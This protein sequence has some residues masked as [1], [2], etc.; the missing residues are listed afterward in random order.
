MEEDIR[1]HIKTKDL[2]RVLDL[3]NNIKNIEVFY[4]TDQLK[5]ANIAIGAMQSDAREALQII[6]SYLLDRENEDE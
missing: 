6:H 4:Y 1:H 3:L 5:M 2:C